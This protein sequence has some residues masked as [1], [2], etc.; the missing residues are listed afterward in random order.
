MNTKT[1]NLPAPVAKFTEKDVR[2]IQGAVAKKNDGKISK[3]SYVAAI[4]RTVAKRSKP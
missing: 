4:Q 3:D 1:V 2:R